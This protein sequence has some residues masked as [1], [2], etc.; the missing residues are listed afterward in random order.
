MNDKH[1]VVYEFLIEKEI[2]LCVV[3]Y[4]RIIM[5]F[6]AQNLALMEKWET[7]ANKGIENS[8]E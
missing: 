3:Q 8:S 4:K 5:I 1:R 7:L 6:W 2:G